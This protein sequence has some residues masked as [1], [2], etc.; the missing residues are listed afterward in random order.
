MVLE[1]AV[2]SRASPLLR[3]KRTPGATINSHNIRCIDNADRHLN[4]PQPI[5]GTS[6]TTPSRGLQSQ[7]HRGD[8]SAIALIRAGHGHGP[9]SCSQALCARR[10]SIQKTMRIVDALPLGCRSMIRHRYGSR[11]A[12]QSWAGA[13]RTTADRV[14][15]TNCRRSS[16]AVPCVATAWSTLGEWTMVMERENDGR[17]IDR[18]WVQGANENPH[19]WRKQSYNQSL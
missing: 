8:F 4:N 7:P 17:D 3:P 6:N 15:A 10:K 12:G 5:A 18:E 19:G 14:W 2:G 9:S 16:S 11:L 1:T 13:R